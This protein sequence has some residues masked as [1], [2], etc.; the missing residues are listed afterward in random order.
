MDLPGPSKPDTSKPDTTTVSVPT[1]P[2]LTDLPYLNEMERIIKERK[3]EGR[4]TSLTYSKKLR[5]GYDHVIV[6]TS[7]DIFEGHPRPKPYFHIL[8]ADDLMDVC[9]SAAKA[10]YPLDELNSPELKPVLSEKMRRTHF[11]VD[12]DE[13]RFLPEE[14]SG[15]KLHCLVD[16]CELYTV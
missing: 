2:P 14:T 6:M 11:T 10:I 1:Y 9:D 16:L 15:I 5:G 12:D 4:T 3:R 8:S 7:G 13:G